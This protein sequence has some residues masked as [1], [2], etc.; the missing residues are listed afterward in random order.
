MGYHSEISF[1]KTVFY[2]IHPLSLSVGSLTLI[3]TAMLWAALYGGPR[4]KKLKQSQ[5]GTE[6]LSPKVS[7]E[8]NL[9]KNISERLGDGPSLIEPSEGNAAWMAPWWQPVGDSGPGTHLSP[10][11]ELTFG[12]CKISVVLSHYILAQFSMEPWTTN[13]PVLKKSVGYLI[14]YQC[15]ENQVDSWGLFFSHYPPYNILLPIITLNFGFLVY[16]AIF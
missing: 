12:H 4:G 15:T 2:I 13:A 6:T 1:T 7:K 14:Y 5:W 10:W 3:T 8:Q 9:A 16:W 11:P